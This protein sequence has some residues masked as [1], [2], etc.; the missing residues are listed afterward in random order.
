MAAQQILFNEPARALP[1]RAKID[2]NAVVDYD[3]ER[4]SH[5]RTRMRAGTIRSAQKIIKPGFDYH[6]GAVVFGKLQKLSTEPISAA[7]N[8]VDE[9]LGRL[10]LNRDLVLQTGE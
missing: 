9:V 8:R 6:A 2:W 4:G 1:V 5:D 7:D 3:R 10:S